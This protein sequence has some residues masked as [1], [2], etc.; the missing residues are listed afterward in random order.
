MNACILLRGLWG[1]LLGALELLPLQLAMVEYGPRESRNM[2]E[3]VKGVAVPALPHLCW[4]GLLLAQ[5][6]S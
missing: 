2:L 5:D 1:G 6:W 4:P 3:E